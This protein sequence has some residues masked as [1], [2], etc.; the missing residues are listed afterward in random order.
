MSLELKLKNPNSCDGCGQLKKLQT[1]GGHM[2]CAI[3]KINTLP[4]DDVTMASRKAEGK[5]T[6]SIKRPQICKD[7]NE[8][9]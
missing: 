1:L 3:Y 7:D 8:G 6:G 4:T 9:K 5:D 2:Q